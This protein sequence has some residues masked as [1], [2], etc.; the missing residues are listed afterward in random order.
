MTENTGNNNFIT[1]VV[2][3]FKNNIL[4]CFFLAL[5]IFLAVTSGNPLSSIGYDV[6]SRFFRNILLIAALVLPIMSGVGLNFG[7]TLGAMGAQLA[8]V[9]LMIFG[10]ADQ[11]FSIVYWILLTIVISGICGRLLALLFN[12]TKGHEMIAGLLV[13]FFSNGI[14]MFILMVLFGDIF[15]LDVEGLVISS[16]LPIKA[17]LDLPAALSGVMDNSL[18]IAY[19][20]VAIIA[21]I[22]ALVYGILSMVLGL[23]KATDADCKRK[24]INK[25]VVRIV[26]AIA[27]FAFCMLT[28]PVRKMLMSLNLPAATAIFSFVIL[29][30]VYRLMQSKLGHDFVS[31]RNDRRIAASVGINVDSTRTK[32]IV[33]STILAGIG[34]IL[35]IQNLGTLNTYVMHNNV[36]MFSIA[37]ILI[38]G[39]TVK[40]ANIKNV[41]IGN[42]IFQLIYGCAPNAS[43][44][45]MGNTQIGEYFRVFLCYAIISIAIVS[46][47]IKEVDTAKKRGQGLIG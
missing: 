3:F 38:G 44:V 33:L 42:L 30:L 43:K 28:P 32:A 35:Y 19:F 9:L 21:F 23:R 25:T 31:I 34:Q 46:Y 20:F 15:K 41:L 27:V 1:R 40:T 37:A 22:A 5:G 36:A 16:G 10:I 14:Y 6:S 17:T 4:V 39:A 45:L 18:P 11:T 12:K 8:F 29:Y 47:A 13:G 7:I 2:S 24:L 26:A